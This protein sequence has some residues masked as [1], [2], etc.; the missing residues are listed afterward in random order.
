MVPTVEEVRT[1]DCCYGALAAMKLPKDVKGLD[2]CEVHDHYLLMKCNGLVFLPA[3]SC[4][5][6]E[7]QTQFQ[8]I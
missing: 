4:A 3:K 2:C 7:V 1:K 5:Y 6:L 8:G